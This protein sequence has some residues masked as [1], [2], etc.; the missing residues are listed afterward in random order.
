[1]IDEG[2]GKDPATQLA[3]EPDQDADVTT[4]SDGATEPVRDGAIAAEQHAASTALVAVSIQPPATATPSGEPGAD[5]D[6]ALFATASS[7]PA[8]DM[9]PS[10]PPLA[11]PTRLLLL[12]AALVA[13]AAAAGLA[14]ALAR[15]DWGSGVGAVGLASLALGAACLLMVGLRAGRVERGW[16]LARAGLALA[17]AFVVLGGGALAAATPLRLAQ[18][19][20][21]EASHDWP[22]ALRAYLLAGET[23]SASEDPA[24]VYVAWGDALAQQGQYAAA[25]DRYEQA[26]IRYPRA[27]STGQ[28][29]LARLWPAYA[30][31]LGLP[32]AT[33][34]FAII[35]QYLHREQQSAWCASACRATATELEAQARFQYGEHLAEGKQYAQAI[36]LL[37]SVAAS[38]A[39]PY[40]APAHAGAATAYYALG[41]VQ[42]RGPACAI[43]LPAYETL[44]TTYK[45]TPEGKRA[46]AALVAPV[47]VSGALSGYP[48]TPAPAM[49]L[50]I[51]V[52]GAF[53][54]N[55]SDDYRTTLDASGH[56]TFAQVQPGKYNLSAAFG[57]GAG[58]FWQDA[59]TNS[60]YAVVVAPLCA[61]NLGTLAW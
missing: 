43:A 12:A 10:Y 8:H 2:L 45:D 30:A 33:V 51:K 36:A 28:R 42:R 53:T 61:L 48:N 3:M 27:H 34:P 55:F 41:Q 58:R 56:F 40:A 18:G 50:S 13:L 7:L 19:H 49:Y 25:I 47:A 44:A 60:P 16:R 5:P 4:A 9:A 35:I 26:L 14:L 54:G 38:T 21:L 32:S 17:L 1:M 46:I 24:R 52:T 31:W 22:G 57:N 11:R 59:K 23:G 15:G 37:E 20:A 6:K 39:S 29:A